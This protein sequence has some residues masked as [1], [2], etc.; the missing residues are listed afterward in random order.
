MA[1]HIDG[2]IRMGHL[3]T[4]IEIADPLLLEVRKVAAREG[5]TLRTL[6]ERGL[7]HVVAQTKQR[8]P[9]KLRRASFRGKGLRSDL[10]DASWDRL[11]DVVYQDLGA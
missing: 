6:V 11:R 9:F 2:A 4:T 5:V 8:A 7:H 1:T 3:K 10:R